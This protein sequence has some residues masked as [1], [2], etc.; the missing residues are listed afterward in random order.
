MNSPGHQVVPHELAQQVSALTRLGKQTGELVGS[1]GRLA[2]R[3]PQLGTAPPAL[4][5]AQ[6]LREAAGESGLTGE[7]GAADT[8]LN[9]FH[10][11]LQ[12]TVKRYLEQEAEA[13]AALKQVGRSAG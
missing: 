3:T 1:A 8:E 4:H 9:G 11:A 13:E 6:R 2:E 5:L 7:I 10:N 12:T